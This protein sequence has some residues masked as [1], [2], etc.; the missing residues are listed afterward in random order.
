[1]TQRERRFRKLVNR[2][3]NSNPTQRETLRTAV[4]QYRDYLIKY[5]CYSMGDGILRS[6]INGE[7]ITF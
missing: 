1:M 4:L 2:Y 3:N 6:Y 5:K 7:W